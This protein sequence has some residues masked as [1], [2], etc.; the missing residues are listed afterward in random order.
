MPTFPSPSYHGYDVTDFRAVNPDYGSLA[1]LRALVAAAHE[2]GIAVLLDLPINHTSDQHPWF[3]D[4]QKPGSAHA[5][6][7]VWS[8]V[9][10]GRRT[11]TALGD[12]PLLR[13]VRGRLA[14]TS[15]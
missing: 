7:Y 12:A 11:G 2:R 8:D 14:R 6:W 3:V 15:T 5:D 1:D 9:A 10:G 13:R 4:S